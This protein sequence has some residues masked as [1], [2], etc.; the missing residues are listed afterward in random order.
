MK[1]NS[2]MVKTVLMSMLTA[3]TMGTMTSCSN[4][5][6]DLM[7]NQE[8]TNMVKPSVVKPISGVWYGCYKAIVTLSASMRTHRKLYS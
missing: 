7:V 2:V 6:D 4:D 3:A 8:V 1:K 5:D